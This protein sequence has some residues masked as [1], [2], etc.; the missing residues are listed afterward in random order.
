VRGLSK[1]LNTDWAEDIALPDLLAR[2]LEK[3]EKSNVLKTEFLY[4]GFA[5]PLHSKNKLII[6][7]VFQESL[8]NCIKHAQATCVTVN[9]HLAQE[10]E[11][12]ILEITDNGVGFDLAQAALGSGLTNMRKRIGLLQGQLEIVSQLQRGTRVEIRFPFQ[13]PHPIPQLA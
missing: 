11:T 2:E 9:F 7:R 13:H 8:N 1:T 10:E 4:D 12:C 5:C 3:L 6:F